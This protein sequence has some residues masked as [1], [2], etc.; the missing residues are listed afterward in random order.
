MRLTLLVRR[1]VLAFAVGAMCVISA[2]A[3]ASQQSHPQASAATA[4]PP[5]VLFLCPHGAASASLRPRIFSAR[6]KSVA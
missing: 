3:K 1:A 2:V 6:R 4:K 5:T